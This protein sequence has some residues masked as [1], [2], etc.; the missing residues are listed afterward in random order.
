VLRWI[1]RDP[2]RERAPASA[3]QT[4][5]DDPVPTAGPGATCVACGRPLTWAGP[6]TEENGRPICAECDAAN[7]FDVLE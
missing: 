6:P 1:R 5:A 2:G 4:D 3:S 7:N